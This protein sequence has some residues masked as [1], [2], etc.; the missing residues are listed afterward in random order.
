[1]RRRAAGAGGIVGA[2]VG[3]NKESEDASEDYAAGISATCRVA[4]YLVCNISSPNTP[5]LRLLQARA[6]MAA[7]IGHALAARNESMPDPATRPPLLVKVAPDLDDA[8]LEVIAEVALEQGVDGI[9]MGNTTLSRPASLKSSHKGE[10]GGLS[11][12]PLF[13]LST[14]RLGALYRL[15]RG[16]I[17]LIGAGGVSS[18]A[19][20]YA[21]IRAGADL[22]QLYSGLVFHGP[23]LV[24][25]IKAD[26]AARLKADGFASVGAA[27]GADIR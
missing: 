2:N 16:R 3:K 14:E 20:A 9:I 4:D 15:V 10:T 22:V 12:Q 17:P 5:G 6:E 25:R 7:V 23:A 13:A 21:K 1:G 19:D 26:L 27:V 8:G 11:G 18:G 24:P